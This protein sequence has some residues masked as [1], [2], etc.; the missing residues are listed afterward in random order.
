MIS[1]IRSLTQFEKIVVTIIMIIY[2]NNLFIDI[3]KVDAAQYSGISLEMATTNSYLEVKEFGADYL[4]KPPLLFWLSSLSIK[5]FGA[6]N[7]AYKLPAFLFL[8]LSFFAV[9]RFSLLYYSERVAKNAVLTLATTQAYFLMT[10]DVRSDGILTSCIIMS[11]WLFSEYFEKGKLLNLIL[12]STFIG[13]GML[14]K[15]PIG[16]IAVLLPLGINLAYRQNWRAIF[17][18]RWLLVI[19][20]VG[21]ILIPM[22]YGLYTQ[23]DLHPEKE[24]SGLY[25]YYW[26]QSFGRITGEN[27]WNNGYPWHFFLGSSIWDYFPWIFPFYVALFLKLKKIFISKI[28]VTEIISFAGF[29]LIF[30]FLSLSKY[31]LPHYIFVTFPFASIIVAEYLTDLDFKFWKR[32]KIMNYILGLIILLLFITFNLFFFKE[33]NAWLIFC[34]LVQIAILIYFRKTRTKDVAELLVLVV[35]INLFFSFVFYPVLLNFQAD[36]VAAKWAS[37]N[38]VKEE[39]VLFKDRSHSFNYYSDNAFSKITDYDKIKSIETPFWLYV[40]EE[41]FSQIQDLK[42]NITQK[43]VFPNYPITKLKLKFLLASKRAD[44]VKNY[45]LIKIEN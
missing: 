13:L 40:S 37:A 16:A 26:L 28:K 3:M 38:I 41:D 20:I 18:L 24:K 6:T 23:F 12:G 8:L 25:F 7:F 1:F 45:Y 14:A 17:D 44:I 21:V 42:M 36:S 29:I 35:S 33:F 43:K 39:V 11:V 5:V 31:K 4:D 32:W 30:F 2:V 34:I 10:N 22:S 19:L 27:T 15:G 9:Y